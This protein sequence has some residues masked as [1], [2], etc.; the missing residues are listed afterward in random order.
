MWRSLTDG[1]INNKQDI[2]FTGAHL[3]RKLNVERVLFHTDIYKWLTFQRQ[4]AR[5]KQ[6]FAVCLCKVAI[7][8]F[9]TNS[10]SSGP[11]FP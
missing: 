6:C 7:Q 9:R 10:T 11:Y 3:E 8:R 5:D 4:T 2:G 1:G